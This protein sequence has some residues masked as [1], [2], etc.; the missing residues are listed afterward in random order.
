M[1]ETQV[2][3]AAAGSAHTC[4]VMQGGQVMCWGA[5]SR[6]QLGDGTTDASNLAVQVRLNASEFLVD[7][8]TVG[9][10]S[11]HTCAY[12]ST[13]KT[14]CWGSNDHGELGNDNVSN[15]SSYAVQTHCR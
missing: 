7:G 6:G 10:G 12:S 13:Q 9:A 11:V 4:A 5:N 14:L 2:F 15:D 1:V 3:E 8:V